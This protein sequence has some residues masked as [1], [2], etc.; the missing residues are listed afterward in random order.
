MNIYRGGTY[1]IPISIKINGEVLSLDDVK[2]IDITFEGAL[3]KSYPTDSD[4]VKVEG[5]KLIVHLS[6]ADTLNILPNGLIHIQARIVFN[7]ESVKFSKTHGAYVRDTEF[8]D[9][10]EVTVNAV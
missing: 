5:D 4:D 10:S 6:E 1:N 8:R 7:D 2:S 3:T 9:A